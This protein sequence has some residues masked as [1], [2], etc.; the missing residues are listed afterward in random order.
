MFVDPELLRAFA[1]QV[2]TASSV[3]VEAGV[4]EKASIAA[5]SLP[6]ST[7]QWAARLVGGHVTEKVGRIAAN[8]AEMGDA[9]RGAGNTYEVTDSDLTGSLEGIF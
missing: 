5:D 8:L 1:G 7:L 6:G 9:V 4:G 2:Q 3:V